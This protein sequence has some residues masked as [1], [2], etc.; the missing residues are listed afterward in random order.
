[1]STGSFLAGLRLIRLTGYV[2]GHLCMLLGGWFAIT[3]LAVGL[4][5]PQ[6]STADLTA[7]LVEVVADFLLYGL[8]AGVTFGLGWRLGTLAVAEE[9]FSKRSLFGLA[10]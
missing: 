8:A 5:Y 6:F 3:A 4:I 9:G 1:M 7:L 10:N 2:C